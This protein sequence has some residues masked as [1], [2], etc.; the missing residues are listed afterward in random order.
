MIWRIVE[1]LVVPVVQFVVVV[2][3]VVAVAIVVVEF[4]LIVSRVVE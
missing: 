4:G 2:L 1:G 3:V